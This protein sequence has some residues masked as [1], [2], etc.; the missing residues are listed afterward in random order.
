MLGHF[1]DKK[2]DVSLFASGEEFLMTNA[3]FDAILLD[4]EMLGISGYEIRR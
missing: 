2:Y 4:I 1:L 3:K